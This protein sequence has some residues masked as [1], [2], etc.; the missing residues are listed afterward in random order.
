MISGAR[1][2]VV[3]FPF[4]DHNAPPF[5]LIENFCEDVAAYL[6]EDDRSV[7]QSL[8]CC[9]L[10]AVCWLL[11]AACWVFLVARACGQT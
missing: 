7:T 3:K 8:A 1:P 9:L 6:K 11:L 2:S 5:Q 4:D 10:F